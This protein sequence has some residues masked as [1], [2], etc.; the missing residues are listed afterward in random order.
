MRHFVTR[1]A[2][3]LTTFALGLLLVFL[4][5]GLVGRWVQRQ[6]GRAAH[7]VAAPYVAEADRR[8]MNRRILLDLRDNWESPSSERSPGYD[9]LE[10]SN[11]ERGE[12]MRRILPKLFPRGH[13][14]HW[15]L[16][17]P[18]SRARPAAG[19][20]DLARARERG[21]FVAHL[22][23]WRKGS[24]T[25]PGA[26]ETLYVVSVGECNAREAPVPPSM[27][28]AVFDHWDGL[29]A[30]FDALP[31]EGIYAV[32]DV[33]GD[34]VEE[35]LLG[36]GEMA[37]PKGVFR[38]RLVGLRG[39]RLRVVH[40]FGVGYVYSFGDPVGDERVITIPVIYYTPRGG[41]GTPLF[42]VDFY[43]AGCSKAAGCGFFP[44]P[45]E[46]R[47]LKSGPLGEGEY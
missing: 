40:D 5:G 33:D 42:E 35:V 41:G 1:P 25:A 30:T 19:E 27:R 45:G 34:D 12:V 7:R 18:E 17:S 6:A 36:R 29:H 43:R 21:D 31:D 38:L 9:D 8:H 15:G 3:L 24:F 13:L 22:P 26:Y 44:R 37:G 14:A 16:C 20:A 11:K 23:Q 10:S 47:Y 4:Y 46:W 2:L 32:R 28:L 39:G